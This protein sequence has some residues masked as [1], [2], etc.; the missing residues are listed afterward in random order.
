MHL[1]ELLVGVPFFAYAVWMRVY[2][3]IAPG[4]KLLLS[5]FMHCV[6]CKIMVIDVLLAHSL[7][8]R[9]GERVR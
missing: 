3:C 9:V 8:T 2:L 4:E 1:D 7:C 5:L 6:I